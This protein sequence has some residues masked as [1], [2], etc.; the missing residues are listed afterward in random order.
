M[1][2]KE[3]ERQRE[4]ETVRVRDTVRGRE[5]EREDDNWA[6][7]V[8]KILYFPK[9][10]WKETRLVEEVCHIAAGEFQDRN[11]VQNKLKN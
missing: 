4:R 2:E 7:Q 9:N 6:G 10:M 5:R 11:E 8:V 1:R 3:R